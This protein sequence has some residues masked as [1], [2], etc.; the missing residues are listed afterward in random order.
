MM[1]TLYNMSQ[2]MDF[3]DALDIGVREMLRSVKAE[4][5]S[6][7]FRSTSTVVQ[8][9]TADRSVVPCGTVLHSDTLPYL[10]LPYP[11]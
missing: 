6:C 11:P 3:E 9:L 4:K 10:T 8:V 1:R 7:G 5:I 2:Y